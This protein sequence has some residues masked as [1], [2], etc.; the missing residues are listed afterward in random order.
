MSSV[1]AIPSR[2]DEVALLSTAPAGAR[3]RRTAPAAGRFRRW[4]N[5]VAG[6][7]AR[8]GKAAANV[9]DG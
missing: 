7:E 8:C 1:A 4:D 5:G 2:L 9:I 3:A 6:L